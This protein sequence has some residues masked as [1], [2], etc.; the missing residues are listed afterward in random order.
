MLLKQSICRV[1]SG[2]YR[3][4][5][6]IKNVNTVEEYKGVDKIH[7]LQQAGR[8]VSSCAHRCEKKFDY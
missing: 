7:M 3:A 4:E 8:T 1:P 5:G 2:Y 6:M